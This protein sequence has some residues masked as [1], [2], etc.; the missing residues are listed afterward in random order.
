MTTG[1]LVFMILSWSIV[2]G[3]AFW[4]YRRVLQA[5]KKPRGDG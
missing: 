3:L 4:S 1:A 2:L 5:G